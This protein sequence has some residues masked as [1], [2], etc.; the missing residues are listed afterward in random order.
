[1]PATVQCALK[2]SGMFHR[3]REVFFYPCLRGWLT[4]FEASRDNNKAITHLL[5]RS[6]A[7]ERTRHRDGFV[8]EVGLIK[9]PHLR[10]RLKLY[11]KEAIDQTFSKVSAGVPQCGFFRIYDQS[12]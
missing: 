6:H 12:A 9:L 10:Q 3:T 7:F 1:M 11:R 2:L 5:Q 8:E 4:A